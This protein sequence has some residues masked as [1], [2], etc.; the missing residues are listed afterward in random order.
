MKESRTYKITASGEYGC[1][2][3]TVYTLG[4]DEKVYYRDLFEND[5]R[6]FDNE[7]RYIL[8]ICDMPSR[9]DGDKYS[10]FY[11]YLTEKDRLVVVHEWGYSC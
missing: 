7:I 5:R 8:D 2:Q 10:R 11:F 1:E 9:F 6:K 3:K 4:F